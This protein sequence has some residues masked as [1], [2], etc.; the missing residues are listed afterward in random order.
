[1]AKR[2]HFVCDRENC[3]FCC[4]DPSTQINMTL[5]DIKWLSDFMKLTVKELFEKEFVTFIPFL[6]AKDF[7]V[8]EVDFGMKRPCPLYIDN[9]CSVYE[10]RPMNCRMFPYWFI[11]N[12]I[13]DDLDCI[14]S[15]EPSPANFIKY[16]TYERVIGEILLRQGKETE[17]FIKRIGAT[18]TIDLS[19]EPDLKRLL[20]IYKKRSEENDKTSMRLAKRLMRIAHEKVDRK[21]LDLK[22]EL[23]ND[24]INKMNFDK[25]I[26]MLINAE[27]I[28]DGT[29]TGLNADYDPSDLQK[30]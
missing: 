13:E 12:R 20:K 18:Q 6:K 4:T 1:M 10:G 17:E 25:D 27:A 15:V 23:I 11:T 5:L 29:I 7:S 16:R 8:F 9:K 28:L 30:P 24:E 19:D 26:E 14:K 2:D 3:N 21:R 22:I